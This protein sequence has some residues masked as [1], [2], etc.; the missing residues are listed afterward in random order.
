MSSYN[1]LMPRV[2][3]ED[4]L[5][6]IM[7]ATALGTKDQG[8]DSSREITSEIHTGSSTVLISPGKEPWESIPCNSAY[9][10]HKDPTIILQG[11]YPGDKEI[12]V[13]TKTHI[14]MSIV[15]L[16]VKS[17]KLEATENSPNDHHR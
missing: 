14:Q 10:H 3:S 16:Y 15:A 11:I 17:P 1:C 4:G 13:H 9:Y 5:G 8:K 2:S 12:Y 7:A 6:E